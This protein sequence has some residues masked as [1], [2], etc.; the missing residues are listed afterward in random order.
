MASEQVRRR[1]VGTGSERAEVAD[2][3]M[4]AKPDVVFTIGHGTLEAG[5]L[6]TLLHEHEVTR[7]IDIR[8]FPGSRRNPQFGREAMEQWVPESGIEYRW[9]EALGG[10]RRSQEKSRHVA[11]RHPAFR[12]YADYMETEAWAGGRNELLALGAE[13]ATAIM[14]S[15]SVWWKC[16]RRLVSD[17]LVLVEQVPVRHIMHTGKLTDHPPLAEAR[18]EGSDLVYDVGALEL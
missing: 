11:L 5:E 10:R 13:Q 6:G 8:S 9:M 18:V 3:S 12:S 16:H 2:V 4:S 17:H 7:L 14:C 15:E 1:G